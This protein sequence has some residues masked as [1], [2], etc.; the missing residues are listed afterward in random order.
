MAGKESRQCPHFDTD[1]GVCGCPEFWKSVP[2]SYSTVQK[3]PAH[4]GSNTR[5]DHNTSGT[6][7][8]SSVNLILLSDHKKMEDQP[9]T[10]APP[11][12]AKETCFFWYH[13]SCRRGNDCDRPHEAHPT[14]PIPPPPGFRHYQPCTLP[15][16]P[17]RTDLEAIK[18]PQEYQH[19]VRTIGGQMD[20]V[21]FS[22]AT[23]IG[24]SSSEIDSNNTDTGASEITVETAMVSL[25]KILGA[26]AHRTMASEVVVGDAR[27]EGADQDGKVRA[28]K[29][30]A[31]C[32]FDHSDYVDLSQLV[33]PPSTPFV[34]E[35]PLLSISH[36]GTLSKRSHLP[37]I[38]SPDIRNKR[39]KLAEKASIDLSD[40]APILKRPRNMSQWHHKPPSPGLDNSHPKPAPPNGFS[41][42]LLPTFAAKKEPSSFTP[43]SLEP[44]K[45]PRGMSAV[46]LTCFFFYHKGYCNPKPGRR[47]D[48]L[49][50]LDTSQQEVSLPHGIDNHD[51]GC[52]LPLCPVRLQNLG[53]VKQDSACSQESMQLRIKREPLTPPRGSKYSFHGYID[54]S[55]RDEI[56]VARG[57]YPKGML[58]QPL[59][60]LNGLARQRFMEQKQRIE[61]IQ[62]EQGIS[63]AD[64]SAN[65]D[66]ENHIQARRK[67]HRSR[68]RSKKQTRTNAAERLCLQMEREEP[69]W[70]KSNGQ[71]N[72]ISIERPLP[73]L[74]F[75]EETSTSTVPPPIGNPN[76]KRRGPRNR[77]KKPLH[78][79]RAE[80]LW[81]RTSIKPEGIRGLTPEV[82]HEPSPSWALHS[83][84]SSPKVRDAPAI[85]VEQQVSIDGALLMIEKMNQ[86]PRKWRPLISNPRRTVSEL[87]VAHEYSPESL[88]LT[89]EERRAELHKR[90]AARRAGYDFEH[91][92]QP[93]RGAVPPVALPH[94][95]AS[96][97]STSSQHWESADDKEALSR[98][99]CQGCRR[100]END[101]GHQIPCQRCADADM[102][103]EGCVDWD[104]GSDK[105]EPLNKNVIT[106]G[107]TAENKLPEGDQ[108]LDWD[109]DLVRLLF[110]ETD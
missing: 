78:S 42:Q 80:E 106:S 84:P 29:K 73:S 35:G 66:T 57:G 48:Y 104:G 16:C 59:P 107:N 38:S 13:S 47:C 17:L 24:E 98:P 74:F 77:N 109:T 54:S 75:K 97:A 53:Q 62:L 51:P 103:A 41:S 58:G 45:G 7:F 15:L 50:Y 82:A 52:S 56:M 105:K 19:C 71:P 9:A 11:G 20:G 8:N 68:R 94:V 101:H 3:A 31:S 32:T 85:P 37:A 63:S 96:A 108:R 87:V 18:K 2:A 23:P 69:V 40:I 79:Q 30:L 88:G 49:H 90:Q 1:N 33:S 91:Q 76:K 6:H 102:A 95:V 55:P 86:D 14:W 92:A 21:A 39:V 89:A 60:P 67:R 36:P 99:R 5:Y 46:P 4:E 28:Q 43:H 26:P 110:G 65:I 61:Q 72:D 70:Y 10:P 12:P 83:F 22:R 64:F 27:E 93:E 25:D 34:Q 44:A 81:L 100:S